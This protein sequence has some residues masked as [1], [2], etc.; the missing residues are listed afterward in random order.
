MAAVCFSVAEAHRRL[1]DQKR[2]KKIIKKL[3]DSNIDVGLSMSVEDAENPAE[4]HD[5]FVYMADI[6]KSSSIEFVLYNIVGASTTN[7][8]AQMQRH[9]QIFRNFCDNLS[10]KFYC[11]ISDFTSKVRAS[12]YSDLPDKIF[13]NASNYDNNSTSSTVYDR[14]TT[15]GVTDLDIS[16]SDFLS[17]FKP[18]YYLINYPFG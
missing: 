18:L 5:N 11:I 4:F 15:G 8:A 13:L 3:T 10:L 7:D 16:D 17:K 6:A 14:T 1:R 2:L 12:I 9:Y